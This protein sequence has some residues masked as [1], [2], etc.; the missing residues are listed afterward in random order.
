MTLQQLQVLFQ[1]LGS[2]AIAGG[3]IY[4]AIQFRS[5]RQAQHFANF[6]KL[7]E[8]Q[9][10]LREMRVMDPTLADVYRHD[11]D[12]T[13][14]MPAGPARQR[15]LREYFFNLMQ[16]SVFEVVWFGHRHGQVPEDYFRSW[17]SRMLALIPEETFLLMWN[18]PSM[19]IFHDDFQRY[20]TKLVA[21]AVHGR[22][23]GATVT[24]RS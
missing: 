21:S 10:H 8:M 4:T 24:G 1:A 13:Q 3:L 6:T 18:S 20:M 2:L 14:G 11:V 19:K 15:A 16:I 5:Y 23:P 22:A 7:V 17:E 12:F 9:M